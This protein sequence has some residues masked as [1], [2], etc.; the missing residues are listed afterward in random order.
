MAWAELAALRGRNSRTY[1]DGTLRRLSITQATLH[2]ESVLDSGVFDSEIDPTPIRVNN[3]QLDGW[4]VTQ[5]NWHYALGAP[6]TG[7]LAGLDGTVG[8]GGRQGQH[9]FKFRLSRLGYLH[10]PTRN[11]QDIGGAPNYNRAN[12]SSA[13]SAMPVGPNLDPVNV[14]SIADWSK[15]WTTP[16]GGDVS[17]QWQVTGETLKEVVTIN[18]SAR[19]WVTANRPP[20]TPAAE[21]WFGLVFRLDWSD[22]PAVYRAQIQQSIE[23]DFSDDEAAIELR[24]AD[25]KALA[26][27][28]PVDHV[29]AGNPGPR[30]PIERQ[31][32]RKRFWKDADGNYYLLVGLRCDTLAAMQVGPL[33]FDPTLGTLNIPNSLSDGFEIPGVS[34][35]FTGV[36]AQ[37]GD[38]GGSITNFWRFTGVG[39]NKDTSI[40]SA[41]LTVTSADTYDGPAMTVNV[42]CEDVDNSAIG[43]ETDGNIDGRT[44]TTNFTNF[45]INNMSLN[46]E[47]TVDIATAV[48]EVLARAGWANGNALSA[49]AVDS[50]C[51]SNEYQILHTWDEASHAKAARLDITYSSG[52]TVSLNVATITA[53]GQALSVVPGAATTSLSAATLTASGQAVSISAPVGGTV[54]PSGVICIWPG[55]HA[56]IPS[57]WTRVTALD[58][59]FPKG[60]ADATDPGGTGGNNTHSHTT[61]DHSH[62]GSHTHTVPDSPQG[63]GSTNRDAGSVRPPAT[64]THASNPSTGNP[65]VNTL[66][67]DTPSTDT[68]NN[69]PPYFVG[70]FIQSNG[71]P[72]GFPATAI[73]PWDQASAPSGWT[74]CDGGSSTPDLRGLYIKGAAAAGNGGGTGGNLT[75]SHTIASHNHGTNYSHAHPNVTS[76]QTGASMVGG[77]AGGSNAA[78]ATQTHTH[79]LTIGNQA[80]DAITGNTD[81]TD[82]PNHE[83]PYVLLGWIQNTSGGVSYPNKAIA[84]WVGTI[85]N[86]PQDW[87]L[88]NGTGTTDTRSRF[89]KGATTL[90]G[91]GTTGGN[92]T[93][94][95]TATGHTHAVA[96]HAHTV[97]AAGGA[98][99]NETAGAVACSTTGH[100]HPSWSNTGASAF[101]S[102][103]GT[104]PVVDYTDTQ[105]SYY[106][107]AWIQYTVS[108]APTTVSLNSATLSASGQTVSVVPGVISVVLA[109]GALTASGQSITIDA[110]G[111]PPTTV[112]LNAASLMAIGQTTTIVAGAATIALNAAVITAS[113]QALTVVPGATSVSISSATLTAN[114]QTVA[115]VPGAIS[116]ILS[117]AGLTA[118]G[119]A[120]SILPGAV[121]SVLSSAILNALGQTT[122][123]SLITDV[124]IGLSAA[125]LT[126][127]GQALV[128]VGGPVTSN[129][130][131]AILS[132]QGQSASIVP[133]ATSIAL[134]AA[135]LT[136]SGQATTISN[137]AG[138]LVALN[139]ANLAAQGQS[140]SAIGG[141]VSSSLSSA[142]LT[143]TGQTITSIPGAVSVPISAA[144]LLAQGQT[145]TPV[146][147]P[148]SFVV[149]V[150]N[151]V[152]QGQALGVIPGTI[153][154]ALDAA[155]LTAFGQNVT[156]SAPAPG[157]VANLSSAVL[158]AIGQPVTIVPGAT[159]TILKAALLRALGQPVTATPET[160][161]TPSPGQYVGGTFEGPRPDY[162][163]EYRQEVIEEL[164]RLQII[165]EDEELLCLI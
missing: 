15:I 27:F 73:I 139:A 21:T 23:D 78:T 50:T 33:A 31:S 82:S 76:A 18:Q 144:S 137:I 79:A 67:N 26:D 61:T 17:V 2:R 28:M 108:I 24:T 74:F 162:K 5:N 149:S 52:V 84:L 103:T 92:L 93:H 121:S 37:I 19:E 123:I 12:L 102:G 130:S 131:A 85:A 81:S 122:T 1:Q 39:L 157:P 156:I 80:T 7:A 88:C 20:T 117:A 59:L 90:A 38:N 97:S 34:P 49:I 153:S 29:F 53:S 66:T 128:V 132:A 65:T 62:A 120:T 89:I 127:Q 138:L 135:V 164:R 124:V 146:G 119:Q 71:T 115:V 51:P 13:V 100:T 25:G 161:V 126:A 68:P 106:A 133:G 143:A 9:W 14:G 48:E 69:E 145:I 163:I 136:A 147:G 160:I 154:I 109:A 42:H 40:T 140:V 54:I 150:A 99:S 155:L 148:I 98:G 10:W 110:P 159:S 113:G 30:N 87:D 116:L 43:V 60:A 57:G 129:L 95:H 72:T 105:P 8:F 83:P 152:A 118:Q 101:T 151:I 75:H 96:S 86:I 142:A 3:A 158:T 125:N 134:D 11:W 44:R 56:S 58:G 46:T 114:G 77:P 111:V 22:I 70:I 35:D 6:Q 63:S 107:V 16:G 104:P 112:T 55:T 91:V 94:S 45:D 165:E 64:H 141:P 4:L 36:T 41:I 47:Y 32:L